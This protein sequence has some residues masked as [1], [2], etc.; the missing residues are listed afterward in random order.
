MDP[1]LLALAFQA[2][3]QHA[4][5]LGH[6]MPFGGLGTE[7]PGAFAFGG[8][9]P[10]AHSAEHLPTIGAVSNTRRMPLLQAHTPRIAAPLAHAVH[11]SPVSMEAPRI[12]APEKVQCHLHT[13]PKKTCKF[14][15]RLLQSQAGAVIEPNGL[16]KVVDRRVMPEAVDQDPLKQVNANTFGITPILQSHILGSAHYKEALTLETFEQVVAE[17][18]EYGDSVEPYLP[19]SN[20]TPSALFCCLYRLVTLGINAHQLLHLIE[21]NNSPRVRCVGILYVR[22]GLP[23]AQLWPWLGEYTLD[24]E[25]FM[26]ST[27]SQEQTTIGQFVESLLLEDRY[28]SIVL[29]RLPMNVK[30][31]LQANIA[32]VSQYRRRAQANLDLSDVYR[33]GGIA[34]EIC[35]DGKWLQ[36]TVQTLLEDKPSR[37][38]V[39]VKLADDET[40]VDVHLG[41]VILLDRR[42]ARSTRGGG[43]SH[44]RSRS[45]SPGKVD[46]ARE[47]G[48][49]DQELIDELRCKDR[50]RATTSGKD[51][52]R[53]PLGYKA[54]CAMPQEMGAASTKLVE[55]DTFVSDRG[56]ASRARGR[57]PS[58]QDPAQRPQSAERRAQMQQ[59]FEKY[60]MAKPTE[61]QAQRDDLEGPAFMRLG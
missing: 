41:K 10:F 51:Y 3:N 48:R 4:A 43:R 8:H 61:A 38:K 42:H 7:V 25:V 29:P 39:L 24:D 33:D 56:A 21:I 1:V 26:T 30:R 18:R 58:P 36:G 60:G 15:Q 34:V 14:C 2:Q 52:A 53:R 32:P 45:R 57:S 46:W 47:R 40:E 50:E 17:M 23:P 44:R 22:F 9:Q 59:L 54:S 5:P 28:Y 55:E 11:R 19:N 13:K 27:S 35:K 49:P 12:P 31:Q 20:T 16:V 37:P 6:T